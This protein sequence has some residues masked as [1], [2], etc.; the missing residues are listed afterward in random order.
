MIEDLNLHRFARQAGRYSAAILMAL[1]EMKCGDYAGARKTLEMAE[2]EIRSDD[3]A[4][5]VRVRSWG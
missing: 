1:A 3:A 2:R 4:A 5:Q